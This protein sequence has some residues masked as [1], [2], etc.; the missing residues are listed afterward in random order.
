MSGFELIDDFDIWV[1]RAR[2]P[3]EVAL[4][5]L[6]LLQEMLAPHINRRS[7][8]VSLRSVGTLI[9]GD[10]KPAEICTEP[11]L[12]RTLRWLEEQEF[13]DI[14]NGDAGM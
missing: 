12:E 4:T 11:P 10:T 2:P 13:S 5:V 6:R 9:S 3:S 8:V 1:K 14:R 7:C